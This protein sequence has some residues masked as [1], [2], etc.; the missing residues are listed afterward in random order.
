MAPEESAS[1]S[2]LTASLRAAW[3]WLRA[4]AAFLFIGSLFILLRL[5]ISRRRLDRFLKWGCRTFVRLLGIRVR[6]EGLERIDP[7]R[8]YTFMFNHVTA[9][10]HFIVYGVVPQWGKGLEAAENFRIPIYGWLA[11]A[12]GNYPIER[13]WSEGTRALIETCAREAREQGF[14]VYCAP[15]G[16]RSRDGLL[17]ALKPGVFRLALSCGREIVPIALIDL[18]PV[19]P[20]GEWRL[21]PQ[22][23]TVRILQ[24]IPLRD[25][26]GETFSVEALKVQVR[27]T[28]SAAGL[29]PRAG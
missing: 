3:L 14:S 12:V 27:E 10:D 2:S 20:R 13:Q 4:S 21:I 25:A 5:F 23:V 6:V 1:R 9:I 26:S 11:R 16:T 28:F 29:K 19:L 17:G 18:F 8:A 15:E 24:P 7:A 22:P